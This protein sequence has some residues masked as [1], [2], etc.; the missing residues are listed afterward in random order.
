ML[1]SRRR[2]RFGSYAVVTPQAQNGRRSFF[3]VVIVA[4]AVFGVI[5]LRTIFMPANDSLQVATMLS[6]DERGRVD[7]T[8][9]GAGES[10]R[11]ETGLKLYDGDLVATDAISRASL[12]FFDGTT[13]VLDEGST[14]ILNEVWQGKTMS[15]ISV[16][17]QKGRAAIASGT[18]ITVKRLIETPFAK[19]EIP[20]ITE[21]VLE[22]E[23]D[24][25]ERTERMAVFATT[26]RGVSSHIRIG[27]GSVFSVI[28][29]E[30]QEIAI[31]PSAVSAIENTE[32]G[33]Y[34]LRRILTSKPDELEFVKYAKNQ[35][36][37]I[38]GEEEAKKET[39]AVKEDNV[40]LIVDEPKEN[41]LLSG[42]A[43]L[44]KG[45]IGQRVASVRVNGYAVDIV[46]GTFSKELALP[47]EESFSIDVQAEGK[48]GIVIEAKSLSLRRDI[49]PPA[50]PIITSP[51]R[52]TSESVSIGPVPVQEETFEITG[53]SSEDAIGIIVNGYQLQKFVPGK[54][55]S[56]LVD[57]A[58]GNVRLGENTYE[59]KA[60]DRAGNTSASVK[61][62][63]LWKAQ[64]APVV[65][66]SEEDISRDTSSY[67]LP[68]SLRVIAPTADGSSYST[69]DAEVLIE[70][71]T[72]PETAS[73]SIN[74]FSL[75]LYLAGKTTWNYIAKEEYGNYALGKNR[76]V[77]VARNNEGKILDVLRYTIERK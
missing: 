57:P 77:I 1:L 16:S 46:N 19:H 26:G 40:A 6:V 76:Y 30:G 37:M 44:V 49:K 63:I 32:D 74:G 47:D 67:L 65:S 36:R 68:G 72:S 5:A 29:G 60:V 56:Y 21:A 10:R 33:P 66:E 70:G 35:S 41:A 38:T 11:A 24:A 71:E 51:A 25:I 50:S 31:T 73:I 61:I 13:V 64:P 48:D 43:V 20:R 59:V 9:S 22:I 45:R 27:D 14:V 23:S 55:W 7:V 75:R 34:S 8:I 2:R 69:S 54:P 3:Y 42:A 53:E 4:V 39:V 52:V 58:I 15:N 28:T 17:L 18:G 62:I 12:L